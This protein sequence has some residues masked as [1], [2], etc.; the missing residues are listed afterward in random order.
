MDSKIKHVSRLGEKIRASE[1]RKKI[2]L[3]K[4]I[5]SEE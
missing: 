2:K 4:E 1:R 3:Q 5:E